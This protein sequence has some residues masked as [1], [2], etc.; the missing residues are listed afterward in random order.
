MGVLDDHNYQHTHGNS[1]GPPTS[2][3]GVSAQQA[4]DAQRRLAEGAVPGASGGRPLRWRGHL[5]LALVALAIAAGFA[6]AA[7]GVGGFGAVA[8]GL[9]AAVAALFGL[10]FL[11]A[12]L[13]SAATS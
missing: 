9:L 8:L 1:L 4:V 12:A 13:A 7:W 11:V 3:A 5:T 2:V 10:I 6:L